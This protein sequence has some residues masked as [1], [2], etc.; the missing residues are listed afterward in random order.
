MHRGSPASCARRLGDTV[1]PAPF[2]FGRAKIEPELVL[3]GSRE[4]TSHR[5]ALPPGGMRNL[6][7]R[8]ALWSTQHRN[9]FFLLRRALHVGWRL[10]LRQSLDC[11][12]Q[13]IDHCLAVANL[14]PLLDTGQSIPQGKQPFAAE[15][16]GMQILLR[17]DGNFTLIHCGWR[18]A[19]QRNSVIADDVNAHGWVLLIDPRR[20]PPVTHTH[21]LF[22][23]QR[24]SIPDNLVALLSHSRAW[25][26][27]NPERVLA[28][29]NGFAER[30]TRSE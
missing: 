23:D 11:R 8:C 19:A 17:S 30:E 6:I 15:W 21:A 16:G 20:L 25:H 28:D 9:H 2:L 22:A 18:L 10:W 5:M 14:A 13:L 7:D 3:Q 29:I 26:C 12:P 1:D 27:S 4:E 24:H